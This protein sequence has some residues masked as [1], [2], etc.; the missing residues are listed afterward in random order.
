VGKLIAFPM[1]RTEKH[2]IIEELKVQEEEIKMCLDDIEALND[3]IVDLTAE[4][5]MLLNRLCELQ[6]IGDL[7]DKGKYDV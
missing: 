2:K 3:H 4:Y 7:S 5:E 6:N 1:H